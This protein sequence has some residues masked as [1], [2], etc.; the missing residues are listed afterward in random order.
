[1]LT[2]VGVVVGTVV[3][4]CEEHEIQDGSPGGEEVRLMS[5]LGSRMSPGYSVVCLRGEE[6]V[7]DARV[8]LGAE[9]K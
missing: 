4:A 3:T 7:G 5:V 6:G 1:M 9:L 2:K 8:T